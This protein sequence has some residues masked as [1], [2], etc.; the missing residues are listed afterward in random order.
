MGDEGDLVFSPSRNGKPV[1]RVE[2]G[3]D[4]VIFLHSHQDPCNSTTSS[5]NKHYLSNLLN[6]GRLDFIIVG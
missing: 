5:T 1:K 3:C 4:V 6:A 2:N